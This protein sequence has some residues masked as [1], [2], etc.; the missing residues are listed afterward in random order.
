MKLII[1]LQILP[2]Q[3]KVNLINNM[4][5]Q[6]IDGTSQYV[7]YLPMKLVDRKRLEFL[8]KWSSRDTLN[9][10]VMDVLIITGRDAS[11]PY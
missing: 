10:T 4:K 2:K 11:F 9:V 3:L 7:V 1:K 6:V 5:Y 8:Q